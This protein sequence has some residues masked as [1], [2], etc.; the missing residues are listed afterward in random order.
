MHC[1][2]WKLRLRLKVTVREQEKMRKSIEKQQ[3]TKPSEVLVTVMFHGRRYA[4]GDNESFRARENAAP[5]LSWP[6]AV[7]ACF[8]S[9]ASPQRGRLTLFPQLQPSR[10]LTRSRSLSQTEKF[11]AEV[12]M[13]RSALVVLA[14]PLHTRSS[15]A[16]ATANITMTEQRRC[17]AA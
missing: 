10:D 15:Q 7:L 3:E 1:F 8:V 9:D 11:S 14:A 2:L 13:A 12:P 6:L 5:S 4:L 16:A 17:A